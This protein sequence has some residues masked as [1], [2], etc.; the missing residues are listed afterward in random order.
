VTPWTY[1]NSEEG[2][3]CIVWAATEA[4]AV[5]KGQRETAL[6]GFAQPADAHAVAYDHV[7]GEMANA[8]KDVIAER[9]KQRAKWG[10]MHDDDHDDHDDGALASAAG[11]VA[12]GCADTNTPAWAVALY[13]NHNGRE[14]MV[15]A[16]ALLLAEI[17]RIDRAD[18]V[19]S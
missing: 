7:G 16:A 15:I 6:P 2:Q 11:F 17:E 14:C 1:T 10:D 3:L 5:Q 12:T 18:G 13:E 8:L 9:E 19:G 4:E